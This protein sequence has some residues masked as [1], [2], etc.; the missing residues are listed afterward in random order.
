MRAHFAPPD[1]IVEHLRGRRNREIAAG[2]LEPQ[3]APGKNGIPG[4]VFPLRVPSGL[5]LHAAVIYEVNSG[6]ILAIKPAV[7][8]ASS[9]VTH[10]QRLGGGSG[11]GRRGN[12]RV[13]QAA[14]SRRDTRAF[15]CA[16][17]Y[18]RRRD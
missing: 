2:I 10:Q 9:F 6:R 12:K 16:R 7:D 17:R 18:A 5:S 8:V 15:N 3:A 11:G 4:H 14:R 13:K 1:F